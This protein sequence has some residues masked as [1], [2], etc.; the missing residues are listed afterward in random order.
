M[1][2][3]LYMVVFG[4]RYMENVVRMSIKNTKYL[5]QEPTDSHIGILTGSTNHNLTSA[6]WITPML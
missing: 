6:W 5:N 1:S 2:L 3:F 4:T